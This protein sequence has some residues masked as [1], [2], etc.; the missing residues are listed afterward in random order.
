MQTI[1]KLLENYLCEELF[2][3]LYIDSNV[4]IYFTNFQFLSLLLIKIHNA[5]YFSKIASFF[6]SRYS[7]CPLDYILI[8]RK[9]ADN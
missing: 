5:E 8:K 2:F 6:L 7:I 9:N 3:Y 4:H 1:N